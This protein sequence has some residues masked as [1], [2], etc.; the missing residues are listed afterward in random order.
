MALQPWRRDAAKTR[1]RG[2]LRHTLSL[3]LAA[4]GGTIIFGFKL[5]GGRAFFRLDCVWKLKF[6]SWN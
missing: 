2:R 3:A 6:V 5:W 4:P 1:R